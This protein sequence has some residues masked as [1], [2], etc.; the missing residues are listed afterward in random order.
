MTVRNGMPTTARPERAMTTVSPANT[1]AEPA[2]P[3]ARAADSS[4]SMPAASWLRCRDRMN[5]E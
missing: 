5:S 2:V 3:V 4:G 1:T